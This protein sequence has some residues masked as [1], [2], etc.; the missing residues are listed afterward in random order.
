M[1]SANAPGM[2]G[3]NG[4]LVPPRNIPELAAAMERFILEPSLAAA[5]GR[6]SRKIAEE[7]FDVHK[8]NAVILDALGL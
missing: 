8:V 6:E 4:F 5:M 1:I 7:K 2:P 3:R